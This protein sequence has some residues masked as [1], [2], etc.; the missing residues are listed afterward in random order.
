MQYKGRLNK[1]N[2]DTF[3]NQNVA[4]ECDLDSMLP[5]DLR[6]VRAKPLQVSDPLDDF[7]L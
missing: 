6:R 1:K 4:T 2:D 5:Q 7:A 3:L